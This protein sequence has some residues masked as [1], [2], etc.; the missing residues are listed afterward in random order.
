MSLLPAGFTQTPLAQGLYSNILFA[1]YFRVLCHS[2]LENV[3]DEA[4]I[5]GKGSSVSNPSGTNSCSTTSRRQ[6]PTVET[7]N[8]EE[9]GMVPLVR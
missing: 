1:G 3:L 5:I 7:V 2:I 6:G 8:D 9:T 4:Y